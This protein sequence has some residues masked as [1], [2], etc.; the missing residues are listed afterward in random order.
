MQPLQGRGLYTGRH[1][2]HASG[3]SQTSEA[4]SHSAG[5]YRH[6]MAACGKD[7]DLSAVD[8]QPIAQSG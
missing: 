4:N 3:S 7:K 6:V 1:G 2:G 5:Q 8:L